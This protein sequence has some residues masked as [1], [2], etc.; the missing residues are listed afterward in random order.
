[1][2]T[3]NWGWIAVVI[4]VVTLILM[5]VVGFEKH[6]KVKPQVNSIT[7]V[8]VNRKFTNTVIGSHTWT[9][10]SNSISIELAN[11][12]SILIPTSENYQITV[13]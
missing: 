12:N 7:V 3:K 4:N 10:R 9:I 2:Q 13:F 1:M 5:T 11:G 6:T 8:D